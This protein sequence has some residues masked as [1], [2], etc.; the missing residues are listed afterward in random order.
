VQPM[1]S[2]LLTRCNRRYSA[3]TLVELLVVIVV[4]A[5]LIGLLVP[6]LAL[7]RASARKITCMS[8]LSQIGMAIHLY[9]FEFNDSIPIGPTAPAFLS[10]ADFYPS[11]GAP[12]SLVSLRNGK[13]VGLG[14]L[15]REHL[16]QQPKVLFCPDPDQYIS[17]DD[18]LANV[19]VRQAQ[20][21]YYYRHA[22]V[23]RLFDSPIDPPL[24]HVAL[25]N[26]GQNR[27]GR[28]VRALVIDTQF[29][30][31]S[32][33]AEFNVKPRT[34]H[35]ERFANILFYDG[36]VVSRPNADGRFTVDLRDYTHIRDAFNKILEVLERGDEEQ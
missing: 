35:R 34:H 4:V 27:N 13:P 6:A 31:P 7:A 16:F 26:L 29:L 10:P 28:P 23:T 25:T 3:F 21:S 32:N 22:S 14:L 12:T 15:L 9:S 18:E 8:N 24:Y 33:L 11:T 1:M 2:C 5:I 20:C 19:G 30:C 36:H 17:A